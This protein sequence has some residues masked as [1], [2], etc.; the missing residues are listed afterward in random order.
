MIG[1]FIFYRI[2]LQSGILVY[3]YIRYRLFYL[4]AKSSV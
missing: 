2:I 3:L 1:K 4:K